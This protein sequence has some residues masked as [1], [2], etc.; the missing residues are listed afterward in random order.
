M[1]IVTT[2]QK[3]IVAANKLFTQKGYA[4]TKTRDIANEANINPAL[5]NYH[6]GSKENLFKVVIQEQYKMFINVM[7]PILSD[8]EASLKEKIKSIAKEYTDLLIENEKLPTFILNEWMINKQMFEMFAQSALQIVQPVIEQQ[9][10]EGD[11]QI[12]VA[13]FITNVLG[14]IIFPFVAKPMIISSGLVSEE[15]FV[16]FVLERE[17]QIID[18][19]LKGA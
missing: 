19:V 11:L 12:S 9:L 15:D 8:K 13:D 10:K 6:F 14:I 2:E 1:E 16:E 17:E 3:I 5:L 18:W 7:I 4:A